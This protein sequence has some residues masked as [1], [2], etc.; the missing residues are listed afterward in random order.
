MKFDL[1]KLAMK[2]IEI[3]LAVLLLGGLFV[4][5]QKLTR[6]EKKVPPP[7]L[8]SLEEER[9]LLNSLRIAPSSSADDQKR[10]TQDGGSTTA[11]EE[12]TP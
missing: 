8:P 5:L 12:K 9:Q 6:P 4:G 10:E 3:V 2:A 1:H 11:P 7:S